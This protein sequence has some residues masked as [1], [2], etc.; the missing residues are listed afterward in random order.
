MAEQSKTIEELQK[1]LVAVKTK[2]STQED[3]TPAFDSLRNK[4]K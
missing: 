2:A 4:A 3:T 1:S